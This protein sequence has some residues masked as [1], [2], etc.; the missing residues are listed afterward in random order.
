MISFNLPTARFNY[1]VAGIAL[2]DGHVLLQRIESDPIWFLPGG[3][4]EAMEASAITLV[5]EMQEECGQTVT[6]DRL[7]WVMENFF[8]HAGTQF[9]ELGLYY[10]MSLPVDSPFLD[11][12]TPFYGD[13]PTVRL[14]FQWFPLTALDGIPL[15]PT[16]LRTA[17]Q[18]IP[19]SLQHI[20]HDDTRNEH[21]LDR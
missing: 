18:A 4:C 10:L 13:E 9:H 3:R 20:V 21:G 12:H 14:I 16:F 15:R 7:I 2:H 1:R 5:R 6:I 11:V 19:P 17:L 8:T